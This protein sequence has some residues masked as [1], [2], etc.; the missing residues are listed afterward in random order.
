M[1][2][3]HVYRKW[4][5]R[6]GTI[7]RTYDFS[8]LTSYF[9]QQCLFREMYLAFLQ[10]RSETNPADF[11][12]KGEIGFFVSL[13][14]TVL[15]T[16]SSNTLSARISISFHLRKSSM[17]AA[18]SVFQASSTWTTLPATETNGKPRG[19]KSWL[20]WWPRLKLKGKKVS[21]SGVHQNCC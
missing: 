11:W 16:I 8:R 4:N 3:W 5:V 14:Y 13:V 21:E 2:H 9:L 12:A 17:N 20:K 19:K 7:T 10:G 15:Y 6:T 1:Q 18:S